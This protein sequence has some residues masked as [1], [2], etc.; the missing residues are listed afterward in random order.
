MAT[1]AARSG[2]E[3][4]DFSLP[5]VI[6]ASSA[7]TL[8]EWYDF[9]IFGSLFVVLQEVLFP[10]GSPVAQTLGVFALFW[11]GFLVRPFGAFFF[12]RIGD[13]VGRKYTFILTISLMGASTFLIGLLPPF[14]AIGWLSVA[15]V[16]LFR[17]L[18]GLALG[19]EYGGAA[20][21][22]AE[23]APDD[24][25]GYYTAYIQTTATLG[26]VLALA[27][28]VIVTTV[29]G[30]EALQSWGW[31]IPFLI[32]GILVIIALYVRLKLRETPLFTKIKEAKQQ[33]VSPIKDAFE[34]GGGRRILLVLL[35]ATAGQAVVWYTGQ[36]YAFAF[37]QDP[38]GLDLVAASLIVMV[39]L[40]LATPF[41][42]I[43][44]RLSDRIGRKP[45]ILG[46]CLI[47]AITYIP[48]YMAMEAF[49]S[50]PNY[51]MLGLLIFIQVIYVTMVYGPI[52]AYLVELFPAKVRYTSLSVPYHF[53]NGW[54]GGGTPF[55][56]AAIAA[57]SGSTLVGLAYPIAIALMTF[58]V[59]SFLLKETNHV[60]IWD[61]VAEATP[62]T[63][64]R[65]AEAVV[66]KGR[67][68]EAT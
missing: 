44:G 54:F 45:I 21:Y 65:P 37:L 28:V 35:G 50:P 67:P 3:V 16:V 1:A 12:G 8:I 58:L 59:G 27:V 46:G 10:E 7:G 55:L 41:F 38:L 6:A 13:L 30:E 29:L 15:L 5:R 63:A 31:R 18:Q 52:A 56:V 24:Q 25:R 42:L 47:A 2:K 57:A 17:V 61:E 68:R 43:F 32:S 39:A 36:F 53:G 51:F 40:I 26:L 64:E 11:V 34:L 4:Y 49:S 22:V 66:D 62:A 14:S 19:G 23:H 33:S 9:Y 48:I 60:R 20:I